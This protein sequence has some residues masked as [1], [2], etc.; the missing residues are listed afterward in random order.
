MIHIFSSKSRP[1]H[2][3]CPHKSAPPPTPLPLPSGADAPDGLWTGRP[4]LS[5]FVP[6]SGSCCCC[7][8]PPSPPPTSPRT[9]LSAS[10]RVL[11]YFERRRTKKIARPR[12]NHLLTTTRWLLV[13]C[14]TCRIFTRQQP[15]GH[16]L[17]R[18]ETQS[19]CSP[20]CVRGRVQ[21]NVRA[22]SMS[23]FSSCCLLPARCWL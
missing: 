3:P 21:F 16:E 18:H 8:S 13:S 2:N 4:T 19:N 17:A 7:A 15:V 20:R 9:I 14:C 5:L 6:R 12:H 10:V 11:V 22:P 23:M 1:Q